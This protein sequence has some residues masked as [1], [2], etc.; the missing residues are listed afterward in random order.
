MT[1]DYDQV[2]TIIGQC[3]FLMLLISAGIVCLFLG[4]HVI[5]SV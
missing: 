2:V 5:A 1:H 4:K 3:F